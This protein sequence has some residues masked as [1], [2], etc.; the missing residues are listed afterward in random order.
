LL[1]KFRVHSLRQ[2]PFVSAPGFEHA[3]DARRKAEEVRSSLRLGL[4]PVG[5]IDNVCDML[6]VTVYRAELGEDPPTSS[7]IS[8]PELSELE[9]FEASGVLSA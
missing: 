1:R 3:E 7:E 8:S 9:E 5:D 6:G 4:G 2:S